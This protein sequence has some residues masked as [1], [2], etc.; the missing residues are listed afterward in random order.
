MR[1]SRGE[2]D[3]EMRGSVSGAQLTKCFSA[4]W[5]RSCRRARSLETAPPA[6]LGGWTA[7]T[8]R[9]RLLSPR[10]APG[11]DENSERRSLYG[12]LRSRQSHRATSRASAG[13]GSFTPVGRLDPYCDLINKA[14]IT[15]VSQGKLK[16]RKS[17][18]VAGHAP[19][20]VQRSKGQA[21][22]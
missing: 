20:Q 3:S 5:S 22:L 17:H 2:L 13:R 4:P 21:C 12:S 10:W 19:R 11:G 15:A 8:A 7:E 18:W 14:G 9:P 16:S 6:V 1:A